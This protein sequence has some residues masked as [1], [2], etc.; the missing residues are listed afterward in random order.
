MHMMPFDTA[1]G[2][3]PTIMSVQLKNTVFKAVLAAWQQQYLHVGT[4]ANNIALLNLQNF[5]EAE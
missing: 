3:P 2:T 1:A 5:L 4:V